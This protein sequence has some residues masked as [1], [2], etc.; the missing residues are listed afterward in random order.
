MLYVKDWWKVALL[1]VHLAEEEVSLVTC[2]RLCAP[3]VIGASYKSIF[4]NLI[5]VILEIRVYSRRSFG[6]FYDDEAQ[7]TTVNECIGT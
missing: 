2:R 5:E 1:K 6:S 7:G 4:P 3:E